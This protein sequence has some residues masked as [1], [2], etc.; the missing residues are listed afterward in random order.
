MDRTGI[1]T[2]ARRALFGSIVAL[3]LASAAPAA[4]AVAPRPAPPNVIVILADD[5]GWPDVSTYGLNR[6]ATPNIDRLATTGVAFTNGYVAASVCAVSRAGL[7]TG[8]QPQSFGFD[9]NLD[10]ST[11][12]GDGLPTSVRTIADRMKALG[13]RTSAIG[14]WH[15][16]EQ[17][18]FYPTNRG[19]DRFWGFLSGETVYVDP[20]TPGIVTTKTRIDRPIDK[21]KPTGRIVEGPDRRPIDDFDK[22]LTNEITDRA[23]EDIDAGRDAKTPFFLYLAYNAPHW[24]L[25]APQAEYDRF[26]DIK[27][28][29]RRTYVAM[30]A[31]LDD[32]VGRV[33]DELERTGQR[34]NTLIVFLSDN[35]CP[36]QF[37]FCQCGH[38]LAAGKFTYLEGGVRTPFLM[39]WPAGLQP[40]A[41]VTT[42][43]SSLD[44][45]PTVLRAA[46]PD[47]PLPSELD[48]EDLV[49]MVRHP[50]PEAEAR[51]LYW[52]QAPV[53]AVVE[54]RWKLWKSLDRGQLSLFDLSADPAEAHDVAEA[55]PQVRKALEAKLDAWRARQPPPAWPLHNTGSVEICGRETERVY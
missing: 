22:Y 13:Y 12:M 15:L 7:L 41:P 50:H 34:D 48:G 5:L 23:I 39:S 2:S 10:D 45:A 47:R 27:D 24:P 1:G 18:A 3:S 44:I 28:P 43:V 30:I 38:P 11:N 14:K 37:G 17:D 42:A 8:R 16:G 25:Q 21:R 20:T 33:L 4:E 35:G 53:F 51:T 29:I 19:F 49:D 54:G 26:P 55:H 31:S 52:G 32:N 46:A 9:Y 6:A 36:I 40:H